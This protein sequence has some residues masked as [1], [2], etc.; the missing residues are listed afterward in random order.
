MP[1]ALTTTVTG[2][3]DSPR[4]VPATSSRVLPSDGVPST[5][6]MTSPA[7]MP[8]FSAGLFGKTLTTFGRPSSVASTRT[9]MPTYEPDSALLRAA[10]SSGVM[11]EVWPVSPTASVRPLI[12]P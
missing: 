5:L 9:P 8:A 10:R 1:S 2:V 12:A 11:K 7:L 4:T 6:T 3:P